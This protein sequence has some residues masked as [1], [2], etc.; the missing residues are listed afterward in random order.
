MSFIS[1]PIDQ[2]QDFIF[3]Q[4]KKLVDDFHLGR[5]SSLTQSLPPDINKLNKRID[6]Y[7]QIEVEHRETEIHVCESRSLPRTRNMTNRS[8]TEISI[9]SSFLF[10]FLRAIGI[11]QRWWRSLGQSEIETASD[12]ESA[13]ELEENSRVKQ[14]GRRRRCRIGKPL[15]VTGARYLSASPLTAA[16]HSRL[17]P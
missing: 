13:G 10:Y 8:D 17:L 12:S 16:T 6:Q 4:Y 9:F 11:R 15:C 7:Y 5:S 2:F 14:R 3:I 1:L